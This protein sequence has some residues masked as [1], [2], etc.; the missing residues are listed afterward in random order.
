MKS[1]LIILL[2]FTLFSCGGKRTE[3]KQAVQDTP[4]ALQD[5][6]LEITKYSRSRTD[7][8]EVLY[9]ELVDKSAELKKLEDD[10]GT[11]NSKASDLEMNFDTYNQKSDSYYNS[12]K[13]KAAS[14][15][16]SLLKKK[17][18][19]LVTNSQN[20]YANKTAS[21]NSLR[22]LISNNSSTI[23]DSYSVLKIVFT[24]QLIEKYQNDNLPDKNDF[25]DFIKDQQ[26]IIHRTVRLTPK[27]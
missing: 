16:D 14:I 10:L 23:N 7:L 18:L 9:Q 21:V 1:F 24:L 25:K 4:K 15:A 20:Q 19:A 22:Q 27:Y 3:T 2:S 12:A 6:K 11:L 8:A 5:N 26:N 17:I 13:E